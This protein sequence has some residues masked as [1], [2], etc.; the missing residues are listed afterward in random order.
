MEQDVA[1]NLRFCFELDAI[2]D[3]EPWIDPARNEPGEPLNTGTPRLVMN[4]SHRHDGK[5]PEGL[6]F[7]SWFGLT[8]GHYWIST[9][10]GEVLRYSDET[11]QR[12]NLQSLYVDYQVG[13]LF[14]D[15][16]EKLPLSLEPVPPDLAAVASDPDWYA[17]SEAWANVDEEDADDS[18]SRRD[19]WYEALE[20]WHQREIDT[21]YLIAGEFFQMWRVEEDVFFRWW[22]SDK[23]TE[24]VWSLPEGQIKMNIADFTSSCYSFFN[25]FLTE[26]RERVEKIERDGW[27]RPECHLEIAEVA[28]QQLEMEALVT[29]LKDRKPV[30]AWEIVRGRLD[31]LRSRLE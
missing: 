21:G 4:P 23:E 25:G 27:H 1:Q 24:S 31:L 14:F 15:L 9:P 8:L 12:W 30:T 28:Q 5:S 16:L 26:M 20:W 13:R 18:E 19:L 17:R 10:L 6:R 7:L 3:I 11:A 2:E 22:C 29:R